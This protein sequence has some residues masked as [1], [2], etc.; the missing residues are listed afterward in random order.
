MIRKQKKNRFFMVLSQLILITLFLN[1]TTLA[2]DDATYKLMMGYQGW[3]FC[4][5]DS[6]AT[7]RWIH[8]FN[9]GVDPSASQ[10]GIDFWPAMEEY[11]DT[12]NTNMNYLD[13]SNAKLFSAYDSSTINVHFRW[14]REYNIHGVYLQRFLNPV[15]T[16]EQTV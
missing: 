6:S 15:A 8:W 5:G 9:S 14:M 12:Y 1:N 4:E 11:K 7:N 13:G 10:I 16:N 2:Q 3:F